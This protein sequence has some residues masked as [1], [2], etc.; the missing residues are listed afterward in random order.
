MEYVVGEAIE[1]LSDVRIKQVAST[2]NTWLLFA[3]QSL[4]V[5]QEARSESP[6]PI[7][8]NNQFYQRFIA[9]LPPL[10]QDEEWLK[11]VL[12]EAYYYLLQLNSFNKIRAATISVKFCIGKLRR[13]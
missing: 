7:K 2:R 12:I 9:K 13:R 3:D 6:S 11:A 4:A 1:D 8:R 5:T 10:S